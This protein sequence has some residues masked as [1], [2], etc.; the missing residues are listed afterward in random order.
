STDGRVFWVDMGEHFRVFRRVYALMTVP[1]LLD[2]P[3]APRLRSRSGR[4]SQLGSPWVAT[5]AGLVR[6]DLPRARGRSAGVREHGAHRA[7]Q[8][9]AE[10]PPTLCPPDPIALV[11]FQ[12]RDTDKQCYRLRLS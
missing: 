3:L 2:P 5:L 11:G 7:R 6:E 10:W 8:H 9:H 1:P 4:A 12:T